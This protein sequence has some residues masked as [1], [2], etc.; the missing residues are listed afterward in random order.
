MAAV[1]LVLLVIKGERCLLKFSLI[2]FLLELC[3]V[4]PADVVVVVVVRRIVGCPCVYNYQR[5]HVCYVSC[6]TTSLPLPWGAGDVVFEGERGGGIGV[7]LRYLL[8][9]G[10]EINLIVEP[11]IVLSSSLLGTVEGFP[12]VFGR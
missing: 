11:A 8:D 12:Q 3:L 6:F 5:T 2:F 4:Q 10:V 7:D 1:F 9:L